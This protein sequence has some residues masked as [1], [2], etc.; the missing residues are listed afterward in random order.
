MAVKE[1]YLLEGGYIKLDRSILTGGRGYGRVEMVPIC[2]ALLETDQG[3]VL[4]ETGLNPQGV[5]EPE[6]A[7]GE[8]AK[9]IHPVLTPQDDVRSRLQ[10]LG[11][12]TKDIKYVINTHL[13]WDHTGG[14]RF[15]TEATFFTQKSEYRFAF[16]PDQHIQA[17]YMRNH[18]DCDVRYELVDGDVEVLPGIMLLHT[19]GH[20]PGHQSL[21][22]TLTSGKH[23]IFAGD[24]SCTLE[25]FTEMLPPGNCWDASAA[26]AS[27][28]KLK[29]IQAL[30]DA[31]LIPSHDA[32]IWAEM[33]KLPVPLSSKL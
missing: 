24:A 13:H 10:E 27:L 9:L 18:F 21:L 12:E 31:F 15:F 11:L 30:M 5:L 3:W 23:L 2:M 19:P 8:R 29:T 4:V 6:K 20:T 14:N 17:S 32:G 1:A 28:H 26:I 25:N 7:W 22:V 33:P 16:Y